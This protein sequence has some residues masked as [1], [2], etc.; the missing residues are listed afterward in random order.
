LQNGAQY[1]AQ[2]YKDAADADFETNQAAYEIEKRIVT[3]KDKLTLKMARGGGVA[4][5]FKAL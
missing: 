2:I 4:V 1:E 5:R 3:K